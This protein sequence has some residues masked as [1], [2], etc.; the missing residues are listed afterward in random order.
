M[1]VIVRPVLTK[2]DKMTF[3]KVPFGIFA[4]DKNWV[5]PLFFERMEHLDEKKNPY[6]E[7]GK[8]QLFIAERDGKPV[9][10]ISAQI[11]QLHLDRHQDA[12]GQFG[13]LDAYDD[14]EIF[15]ALFA[16]AS[17]WLKSRGIKNIRGPFSF[18]I[19]DETG[20][21]VSGFDRPPSIMMGHGMPYYEKHVLANGFTK[22][23]NCIA[24]I[25]PIAGKMPPALERLHNRAMASGDITVRAMDK[26]FIARDVDIIMDIFND[27]WSDNWGY[28]PFTA[29][30]LNAL[31]NNLKML[32]KNDYVSIASYK[33]KPAAFAVTLPNINEWIAGLD[34]KLLPF[35]WAKIAWNLLAK[36]PRSG[37]MPLLGVR[38]EFHDSIN[39]F[40]LAL[41]VIERTRTYHLSRGTTEFELSW[42]LE[43]NQG[44]NHI[45]LSL[46]AKPYKIYS[47][48][49][50]PL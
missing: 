4:N 19:N 1:S 22:I 39:G 45:I 21:L 2:A 16:T 8:A 25:Y 32:V 41:T 5:A 46:G 17:D 44:M 49:E 15:E 9:G 33:G 43:D 14:P 11:D 18:S 26:K 29:A 27:A 20:L 40:G 35:G 34:G 6:F 24:Y 7:H 48:Y 37:R 3:L 38:K 10:R 42:I 50:R 36:P 23:K 30:E 12:T 47:V 28:I 13:F 31:S